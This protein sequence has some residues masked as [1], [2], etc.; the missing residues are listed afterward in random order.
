MT[1][2]LA[3]VAEA[4]PGSGSAMG[5]AGVTPENRFCPQLGGLYPLMAGHRQERG[6]A[7][8]VTTCW[9]K[10]GTLRLLLGSGRRARHLCR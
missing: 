4:G 10:A 5:K 3:V 9:G 8:S 7:G 2:L 1:L 6:R